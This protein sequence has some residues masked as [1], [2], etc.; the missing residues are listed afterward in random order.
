MTS[1]QESTMYE[2]CRITAIKFCPE[3]ETM[4]PKFAKNDYNKLKNSIKENGLLNPIVLNKDNEIL[5]GHNRYRIC[6]EL[7][8]EPQCVTKNY[9]DKIL[10]KIFVIESNLQ[11][12]NLNDF[13][14]VELA[15]LLIEIEKKLAKQRQ[16]KGALEPNGAKGRTTE[17]IS[18]KVA[19]SQKTTE[20]CI[21]IIKLGSESDKEGLRK[22]DYN[23]FNIYNK[24]H[25]Q[26]KKRNAGPIPEGEFSVI[27]SD[28][29]WQYYLNGKGSPENHYDTMSTESICN[30]SIPSAKNS[31]LFLWATAP[32]LQDAL[33]VMERWGF[34]YKTNMVW[35]KDKIGT[36]YYFRGQHELLLVGKKGQI[37]VPEVEDIPNSVLISPRR[38]HSEKPSE[39]YN[40]IEKMY[41]NQKYLEL[42]AR[43]K[44]ENW[45]SW[46]NELESSD[47]IN[48]GKEGVIAQC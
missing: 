24:I 6:V 26:E 27:L 48:E 43:N 41:P 3:Y 1:L 17:I 21:K 5:D 33:E 31:I 37:L 20:R 40:I 39:V 18:K 2:K 13:Q 45:T 11:R 12:R 30:L 42:F 22:G 47:N 46:G 14:K 44:R 19:V 10:E 15:S 35:V 32:K 9:P 4:L 34:E 25:R 7:D 8:I 16:Q 38:A 28:P 36:G 23:I 29:P